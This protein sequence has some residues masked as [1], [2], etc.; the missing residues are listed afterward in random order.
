MLPG[1]CFWVIKEELDGGAAVIDGSHQVTSLKR[2]N[3]F[4]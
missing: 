3:K 2:E 1:G 4:N